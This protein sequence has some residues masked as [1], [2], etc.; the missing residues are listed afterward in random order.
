MVANKMQVL[1]I[2]PVLEPR[3]MLPNVITNNPLTSA[4]ERRKRTGMLTGVPAPRHLEWRYV[5]NL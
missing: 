5:L 3:G 1:E 2:F 4:R